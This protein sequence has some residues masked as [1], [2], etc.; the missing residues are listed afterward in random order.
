MHLPQLDLLLGY[1]LVILSPT[2]WLCI[3]NGLYNEVE[4]FEYD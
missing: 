4:E 1:G 3:D 2:C